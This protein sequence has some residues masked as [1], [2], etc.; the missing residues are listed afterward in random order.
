MRHNRTT[1][2]QLFHAKL[3]MSVF[4][5]VREQRLQR[6]RALLTEG[7]QGI[8][9]VALRVGYRHGSNLSRAFKQ[10]FGLAPSQLPPVGKKLPS[11]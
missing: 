10:R 1:L 11:G 2:Q 3:G 5:Y 6:A 8:D 4:G 7:V 9:A